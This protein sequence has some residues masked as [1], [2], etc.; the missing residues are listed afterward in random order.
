MQSDRSLNGL[1]QYSAVEAIIDIVA[2]FSEETHAVGL[3]KTSCGVIPND[4]AEN[5][6]EVASTF[7][8][9]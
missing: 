7:N 5:S 3:E 1:F 4:V 9:L 2:T 6:L 8:L